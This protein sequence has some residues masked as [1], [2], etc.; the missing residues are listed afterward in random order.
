MSPKM[1]VMGEVSKAVIPAAGLGTRLL[2]ATKE[3]PKEMLPLF[4]SDDGILCLKPAVQQI[5]E[6]MFE[7]GLRE[8]CFVVGKEKRAIED[9]FTPDRDYVMG[10]NTHG[11]TAQA[12]QLERFYDRIDKST[13]VWVNQPEPQ[14]FGHAVLLAEPLVDSETFFVHAGDTY[15]TSA[16][17]PI[18][19]RLLHAH[20]NNV[21]D[22]TLTIQQVEDPRGY[23]IAEVRASSTGQQVL[24]VE[25]K[26][27]HPKS[28]LAIMPL[29][30]FNGTIF[31][32]LRKTK[33]DQLGEIQLTDAIQ[34]LLESGHN[35]QAVSLQPEDLRL[36]IG[37]PETYWEALE[38]SYRNAT[39]KTGSVRT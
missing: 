18:Q 19:S 27:T 8:F 9:H 34:G 35:V 37:T 36:D 24:G 1:G 22:A 12:L 33:R 7:L 13:I 5:F 20:F 16:S 6:Q 10:L 28:K 14:G 4:A 25:E 39:A 15:I 3:Q 11:K 21:A 17:I 2:S 31:E 23:G 26:P 29:Y 32:S 38:L 30:I